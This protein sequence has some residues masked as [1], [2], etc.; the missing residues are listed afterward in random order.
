M[1][2]A[3]IDWHNFVVVETV[4]YQPNEQ[5]QFPPPLKQDEVGNRII[6]E[7]RFE[8]FGVRRPFH[9]TNFKEF[10]KVCQIIDVTL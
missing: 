3:Q 9:R 2:Y 1:A 6:A 10:Q 8:Q 5:G 7:E 4:D